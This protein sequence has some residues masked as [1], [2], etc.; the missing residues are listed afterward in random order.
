MLPDVV[1]LRSYCIVFL[2]V[3]ILLVHILLSFDCSYTLYGI[4]RVSLAVAK[5]VSC[6]LSEVVSASHPSEIT[7]L[8]TSTQTTRVASKSVASHA[9]KH[10]APHARNATPHRLWDIGNHAQ[11]Y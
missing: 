8:R 5:L 11:P 2:L 9:A 1:A 4:Q 10:H 7:Q 3:H 6:K